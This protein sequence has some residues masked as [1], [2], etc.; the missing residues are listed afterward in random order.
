MPPLRPHIAETALAAG[1]WCWPREGPRAEQWRARHGAPP[2][3]PPGT[4]AGLTVHDDTTVLWCIAAGGQRTHRSDGATLGPRTRA[5]WREAGIALPRAVPVL[6]RSVHEGTAQL[7]HVAYLASLSAV[8][9]VPDVRRPIDGPSFG[10]AFALALASRVLGCALPGDVIATAAMD[11]TGRV[12]RVGGLEQKLRGLGRLAPSVRWVLVAAEQVAEA[13]RHAAAHLEVVGVA[14]AAEAI[15]R[16]FG[17]RLSAR[18]V[19]AGED[20]DRRQELTGSFFRLALMGSEALVDWSPV[21]RGA[22]L[23]LEAWTDLDDDAR[24]RLAFAEAVAARHVDNGGRVGLPP[25]GWL[26]RQPRMIRAQVV[27]HL[28][29]QCADAGTPEVSAIEPLATSFLD[30][31]LEESSQADLRLRGALARLLAVTGR[32]VEA[33]ALQERV[34]RAFSAI[35]ADQDVAYPLAEWA[36]LAGVVDDREA[37]A[38]AVDLHERSRSSGGYRGLGPRYVEL[39]ILKASR[40]I[41]PDNT[42]IR[43]LALAMGTDATLPDTLRWSALRWAGRA[44]RA[45]LM[46]AADGGNRVAARQLVLSDLDEAL[47]AGEMGTAESCVEALARYDPGPVRH[48]RRTGATVAEIA[49]QYPY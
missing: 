18:L 43:D 17:Q 27:A 5:A 25:S 31:P 24:Y 9:I 11:A 41:E 33:L 10:L 20:K 44:G 21:R 28:V 8:A 34:A 13:R 48:L 12:G 7:P 42:W 38:R 47:R 16:V 15:D 23:A 29:Q 37:L 3:L 39:A 30:H 40:L 35:Y 4:T 19:E 36:R 6:W 1:P 46:R 45:R 49:R 32:P 14:H 26:E 22:A 2:Q